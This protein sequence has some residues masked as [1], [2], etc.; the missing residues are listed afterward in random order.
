MPQLSGRRSHFPKLT[1]FGYSLVR[2]VE[3]PDAI[4]NFAFQRHELS[5]LIDPESAVTAQVVHQLAD[6]ELVKAHNGLPWPQI[7][8]ACRS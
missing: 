7:S 6:L 1:L 2:F 4:P 3:V 5:D 8:P